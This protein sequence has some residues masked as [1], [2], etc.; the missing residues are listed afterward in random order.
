[1]PVGFWNDPDGSAYRRAYFERYPGIWH[2][3]DFAELTA[4]DGIVMYGRS[5][6]TL[7]PGGVR[8]GT[9]EIYR[10]LEQL[11]E[12]ADS[13]AVGQQWQGD[14]RIVLFVQ[15][16]AAAT[17]DDALRERICRS[18]RRDASPRHVPKLILAVGDIPRTLN[19]KTSERAVAD[20]MHG[21]AV[22]N[23]TALANPASLADFADRPELQA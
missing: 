11:P 21:R 15:L 14:T 3:G 6:A 9:A 13:V 1:M 16:A 10:V 22:G 12:I 4:H 19:G 23:L 5:D 2:H 17:L 18:L 20:A 7:N 8:I